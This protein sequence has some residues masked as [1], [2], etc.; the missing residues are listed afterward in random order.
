M[1]YYRKYYITESNILQKMLYYRK[2]Y[3]Y[4]TYM[5]WQSNSI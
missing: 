1:L 3:Y 5:L 2:Y 4:K